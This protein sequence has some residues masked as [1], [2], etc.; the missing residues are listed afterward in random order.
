MPPVELKD[1]QGRH[2]TR[3]PTQTR[4]VVIASSKTLSLAFIVLS[5]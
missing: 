2:R 4:F 3:L 5:N 1:G